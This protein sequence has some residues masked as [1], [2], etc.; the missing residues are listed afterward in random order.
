[1]LASGRESRPQSGEGDVTAI[2]GQ[3]LQLFKRV[4]PTNIA[5]SL[6]A[7]SEKL[8]RVGIDGATLERALLN[9]L[10]NAR[11]A[12]PSGGTLQVAISQRVIPAEEAASFNFNAG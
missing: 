2:A 11:D 6:T 7:T 10:V 9:L 5:V 4:A 12:M 3:V 8:G 1:M